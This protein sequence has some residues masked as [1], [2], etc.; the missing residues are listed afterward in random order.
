VGQRAAQARQGGVIVSSLG[1]GAD[2]NEALMAE[3]ATQGGGRFYHLEHASQIVAYLAG[4]LGE[5]AALAARQAEVRL[6]LPAG[7]MI[8]PLSS[9]YPAR[10]GE[11]Q[12][13]VALGDLPSD[14]ELEVPLRLSLPAQAAGARL[15]VDGAL[16]Y[17]SPAGARLETPLNRVTLRIVGAEAYQPRL[18]VVLPVAE[19][20]LEQIKATNVLG[21]ARAAAK[22]PH[23][24][25]RQAQAEMAALREYAE[26]LGEER[27]LREVAELEGSFNVMAASPMAAKAHVTAAIRKQR[28]TKD[29]DSK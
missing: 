6:N 13:F 3:I 16:V 10:Q 23:D 29:F 7:A 22:N 12:A 5:V 1:V 4:E 28:S 27:A 25:Q 8:M 14:L 24:R 26:K 11:G 18:G 20:V 2:Y 9:A 15:S 17:A 21:L 19:R